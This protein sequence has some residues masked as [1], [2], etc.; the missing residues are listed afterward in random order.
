LKTQFENFP[1]IYTTSTTVVSKIRGFTIDLL[2][3]LKNCMLTSSDLVEITGKYR[4]Y[5]NQ[6]LYRM[7]NYGLVEKEGVFWK[8]SDLGVSLL[9]RY[10]EVSIEDSE[11]RKKTVEVQKRSIQT[12]FEI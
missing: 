1:I 3:H 7:Q 10:E 6:Y 4:Q 11:N 9:K 2:C 12:S 8:I 5:I